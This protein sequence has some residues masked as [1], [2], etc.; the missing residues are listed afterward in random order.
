M[1]KTIIFLIVGMTIAIGT[2]CLAHNY[3]NQQVLSNLTQQDKEQQSQDPDLDAR[4]IRTEK[5]AAEISN[6]DAQKVRNSIN[7][8]QENMT[9]A[10]KLK[11]TGMITEKIN[12]DDLFMMMGMLED[13]LSP[14]DIAKVQ[15]IA[16]SKL[17][18]EDFAQLKEMYQKYEK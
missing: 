18:E 3:I 12:R 5:P 14:E 11:I 15:K 4:I 7:Y 1:K 6:E 16:E 8:I 2:L 10:D 17:T 9:D 13:G